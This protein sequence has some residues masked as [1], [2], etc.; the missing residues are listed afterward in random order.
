M[1]TPYSLTDLPRTMTAFAAFPPNAKNYTFEAWAAHHQHLLCAI[2]SNGVRIELD[3][4]K[5]QYSRI[6]GDRDADRNRSSMQVLG[7]LAAP[8][9]PEQERERVAEEEARARRNRRGTAT[10]PLPM[11]RA[12]TT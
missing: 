9:T 4:L 6:L 5:N 3:A 10:N 11:V 2:R 1:R 8:T 7:D 12:N